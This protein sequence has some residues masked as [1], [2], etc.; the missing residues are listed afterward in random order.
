MYALNIGLGD[1][2]IVTPMTFVASANCI[3]FQGGTP[4][5][6]DVDPE[7][8]ATTRYEFRQ[9]GITR[10]DTAERSQRLLVTLGG[11]DPANQTVK[12]IDAL[13]QLSAGL[14]AN[15]LKTRLEIRVVIGASNPHTESLESAR[16]RC[17]MPI[18]FVHRATDMCSL[19]A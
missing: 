2:V 4:V 7:P 5:F 9:Q 6:A 18:E 3:A 16:D 10:S 19:M 11:S 1:E 17:S 8:L 12:V 13:S 15:D 14:F